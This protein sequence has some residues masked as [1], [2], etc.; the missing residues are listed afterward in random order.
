MSKPS[1]ILSLKYCQ[2]CGRNG[3]DAEG[4]TT[5]PVVFEWRYGGKNVYLTGSFSQ[6]RVKK[7]MS[8]ESQ[9]GVY[10]LKLSLS[11]G[12]YEYK[13]IVDG[14]WKH[15][16]LQSTVYD[17]FSGKNNIIE[18]KPRTFHEEEQEE[19]ENIIYIH[20]PESHKGLK[21]TKIVYQFPANWVV[22]KGS[23]DNWKEPIMLKKVKN[24]FTGFAEF[25]VLLKIMPG[26]YEFK[27]VVD[28]QW[29]TNPYLPI[30]TSFDGYEN[31]L[32]IVTSCPNT[33]SK[34]KPLTYKD[35]HV[36]NWRREEG[37]WTECGR[38]H[39]T[40]QGHSMNVVSDLVYIF[41]GLANN[42]FTNT[43]YCFD[44]ATN[45]FS[46]VDD[47]LGDIPE[48]RAFHHTSVF[49]TRIIVSGGFNER[50]L[51]DYYSFNTVSNKWTKAELDGEVPGPRERGTLAPYLEDKLVLFG[52][53]YCSS[54]ME[55]EYYLNDCYVLNITLMEWVKPNIEGEAP[56]KRSAHTAD[57]IKEKMY[58]FGGISYQKNLNDIWVLKTS[59]TSQFQWKQIIPK[60]VPPEPRHGHTSTVVGTNIF[61]HG[62][63]GAGYKIFDDLVIFDTINEQW[64]YPKIGGI[65]PPPRYYHKSVALNGG[66]EIMVF[67]GIRPKEFINYPRVYILDTTPKAQL[68]EE[69]PKQKE[70]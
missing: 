10:R 12:I 27:F 19:D 46:V 38:I 42:K 29:T 2:N 45:E 28:G 66:A 65:R 41:G 25:F 44:P 20:S 14:I 67:G 54:D 36:L 68:E 3:H 57:F 64:V 7:R 40:L 60:G 4:C 16:P 43:L 9:E 37:K 13:F 23:W 17:G 39:H 18:V 61:Y 33:K 48:P 69:D 70:R 56:P 15:D 55:A 49:G 58:V 21:L 51:N 47:Q 26:T 63:R 22:I 11:P 31:N 52:G 30:T 24:S 35:E 5:I 1:P 34:A 59:Q 62:G 6:W 8:P 32:L 53:Y 50:I